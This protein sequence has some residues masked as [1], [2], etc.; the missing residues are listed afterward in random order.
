MWATIFYTHTKQQAKLL[1]PRTI[2]HRCVIFHVNF[3]EQL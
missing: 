3:L 2:S 1:W